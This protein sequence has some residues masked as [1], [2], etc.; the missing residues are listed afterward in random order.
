V[1]RFNRA[2]SNK[3]MIHLAGVA[4]GLGIVIHVGRCTR[5]VY[6]TPV[7]VF[8]TKDGYRFALVYGR[9]GDWVRNTLSHGAARLV[10]RRA[11]HEL[12]DPELVVDPDHQHVPG[13]LRPV[14]TL[15]RVSEFLDVTSPA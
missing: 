4:P 10:T 14:L 6:R 5:T 9:D 1:A 13:P 7:V 2:V 3:V 11:A 12:A 8:R 15:L